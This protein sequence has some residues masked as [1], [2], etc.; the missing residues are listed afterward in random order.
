MTDAS[1]GHVPLAVTRRGGQV[2]SIHYGSIAVTDKSGSVLKSAGNPQ[3]VTFLRS[4]I[5]P[6]QAMPLVAHAEFAQLGLSDAEIATLCSSHSG[7]PR[8]VDAVLSVL[9]KAGRRKEELRCGVHPPLYFSAFGQSPVAGEVY[10]SVQNNCSGKHAGMLALCGLLDAAPQGYLDT[11]H[12]VQRAI[13][14]AVK[15]F[16]DQDE[17]S[18]GTDGCGAPNYAAPLSALA[19]A[20]AK[21][22]D[23]GGDVEYGDAPQRIFSAFTDHPEMVSGLKRLDLAITYTGKGR[24]IAKG[25]AEGMQALGV[26]D[27][28][29]GIAMKIA[30]GN[31]RAVPVVAVEVLRQLDLVDSIE[32]SPLVEYAAPRLSNFRGMEVGDMQ[33]VFALE[34]T[35]S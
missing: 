34:A 16:T 25:G 20:F 28:G 17:L 35:P 19:C 30:D 13:V 31:S 21:L 9:S 3:A 22:C 18:M 23:P 12:P 6:L 7:E 11:D 10:T 15:Y 14:R 24:F 26:R 33:S 29:Y 5:K 8:H 2:E 4:T 27:P 32:D 1:Y